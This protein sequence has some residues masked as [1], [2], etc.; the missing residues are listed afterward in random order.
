MNSNLNREGA[1]G[2]KAL[3]LRSV[4]PERDL[5][6]EMNLPPT[7]S[8]KSSGGATIL[9]PIACTLRPLLQPFGQEMGVKYK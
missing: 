9:P 4:T 7:C 2:T 8:L 5:R 3:G 1:K 6:Q